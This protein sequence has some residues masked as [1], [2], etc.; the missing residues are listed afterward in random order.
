[1]PG[2]S[3]S[4]LGHVYLI[5]VA[6]LLISLKGILAK[7][8]Y[9]EGVSVEAALFLRALMAQPL[10]WL[11]VLSRNSL[12]EVFSV[13]PHLIAGA[14]LVGVA[15]YY[16]GAW[17][18]FFA[19]K[20]IDASLERVLLFTYPMLVVIAQA[21]GQRR[22]PPRRVIF[23]VGLTWCG[24][25]L[26]VGAFESD[27]W[28][29]NQF[30]AALVLAAACGFA[31]YMIANERYTRKASSATFIAFSSLA[32]AVALAVH[33]ALVA[34]GGEMDISLRAWVY[35]ALMTAFTN[36]LPLFFFSASIRKIGA[37]RAAIISSIGP[38]ATMVF[39]VFLLNE[40][41]TASQYLGS[42]LIVIGILVLEIRRDAVVESS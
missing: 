12:R 42:A 15:C 41:M 4:D 18:D 31:Y 37:Q 11:W 26:A 27:V 14:A 24:I 33:Y 9:A 39:A 20:L 28:K 40:V 32:A 7:F 2:S 34:S 25:A 10:V 38:P 13:Q 8:I 19:L 5:V 30:G 21:V 23:A 22:M 35:I 1:M 16:L 17:L 3:G 6:A 29:A 36:V